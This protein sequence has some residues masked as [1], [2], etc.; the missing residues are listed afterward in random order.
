[1]KS[2]NFSKPNAEKLAATFPG[3][4]DEKFARFTSA[5]FKKKV[6]ECKG[7]GAGRQHDALIEAGAKFLK[8]KG[9]YKISMF[10]W[11]YAKRIT[12]TI[13]ATYIT[14]RIS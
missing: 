12:K 7:N 13:D 2:I 6:I 4:E 9:V 8:T 3:R 11:E 10:D 5:E 14:K 1:M